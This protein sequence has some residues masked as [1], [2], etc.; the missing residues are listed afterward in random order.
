[1]YTS[2]MHTKPAP[3]PSL[4]DTAEVQ[5]SIVVPMYNEEKRLPTMLDEACAWLEELRQNKRSL[6]GSTASENSWASALTTPLTTYE[7]VLVDDGSQD[8]THDVA[9]AYANQLR[10]APG[11]EIRITRLLTNR[12]KGAAV[13]HGVLHARGAYVLFADADGATRFSELEKIAREMVRILTPQ[14]HGV[15][16]GSRAHLVKSE[17]VVKRS[18]LRNLLMRGFH[19]FLSVLMRPPSLSGMYQRLLDTITPTPLKRGTAGDV[20]QLARQPEIRDTQCGFKMFSRRTAVAVF[21]LAH[22]NR[23][24]FDVELLLLAE[25]ASRASEAD[26]VQRYGTRRSNPSDLLLQL[27]LPIAEVPVH[28][29][30]IDGSKI[31]LL[32]DSARMGRDLIIIRLNYALGRWTP[33]RSLYA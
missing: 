11:A 27:P 15:V 2:P 19:L 4:Q 20:Q 13:R 33:P 29:T 30:E 9:M 32:S 26:Y 7:L 25:M 6:S 10:L 24:I 22:I 12:G 21:P 28:W 16:V 1:M 31:S 18:M 3:L 23:W 17:A 5:L 8:A 14:G